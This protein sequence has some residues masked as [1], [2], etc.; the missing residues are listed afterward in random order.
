MKSRLPQ[1]ISEVGEVDCQC[2]G[3]QKMYASD[4]LKKVSDTVNFAVAKN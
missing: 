1:K 4:F 2:G 3:S